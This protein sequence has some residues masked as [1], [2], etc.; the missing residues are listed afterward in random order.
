MNFKKAAV[1][2]FLEK[3]LAFLILKRN[4][5][6]LKLAWQNSLLVRW[7]WNSLKWYK[8]QQWKWL[9]VLKKLLYALYTWNHFSAKCIIWKKYAVKRNFKLTPKKIPIWFFEL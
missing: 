2:V 8:N 9:L 1:V 7:I 4:E 3:I 6:I 5:D